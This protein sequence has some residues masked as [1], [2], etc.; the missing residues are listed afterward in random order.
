M[1]KYEA[2]YKDFNGNDCSETLYFNLT[3][4]E[5]VILDNSIPGGLSNK[6]KQ[7]AGSM[8]NVEIMDT[9]LLLVRKTYGVKS[10]DGKRFIKS[11]EIANDFMQTLAF[12]VF[13]TELL[14]SEDF[15]VKFLRGVFP[16]MPDSDW[17]DVM[18]SLPSSSNND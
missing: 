12:D 3:K 11:D 14:S 4:S 13:F 16:D 18:K 5:V 7:I 15:I 1:F 6:L 8:N 2:K 9:F 10:D 17:N